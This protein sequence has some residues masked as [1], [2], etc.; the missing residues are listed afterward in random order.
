MR[1]RLVAILAVSLV[2]CAGV[3]AVPD[4]GSNSG[5][6]LRLGSGGRVPAPGDAMTGGAEGVA[7]LHYNPA[8]L[9]W[10]DHQ[11]VSALYQ[12]LVLGINRGEM[13]F[14]RPYGERY[15]F[16]FGISYL[17]YGTIERTTISRAG[18][19]VTGTAAGEFGAQDLAANFSV[20]GRSGQL[21]WGVTG[22]F[23]S[24]TID[25]ISSVAGAF[26]AGAQ[27]RLP[28][29]PFSVGAVI[30]NIGTG[31]KFDQDVE[32]LPKVFRV[33][34]SA[35]FFDKKLGLYADAE[36][37][38]NEEVTTMVGAE[39]LLFDL[40]SLRAGYDGR[41]DVDKGLTLGLGVETKKYEFNYAYVP[42][43]DFG[44]TH[45]LGM[46]YH[47]RNVGRKEAQTREKSW[48][49]YLG[50][51]DEIRKQAVEQKLDPAPLRRPEPKSKPEPVIVPVLPPAPL[52][53]EPV[54]DLSTPKET[55]PVETQVQIEAVPEIETMSEMT[56][57]IKFKVRRLSFRQIHSD[58]ETL[59]FHRGVGILMTDYL[60]S[61]FE[62]QGALALEFEEESH[63]VSGTYQITGNEIAL[64]LYIRQGNRV[65][66]FVKE[67]LD[68]GDIL[69]DSGFYR[70]M[71][72][73][74]YKQIE[75]TEHF[76]N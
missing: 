50:K 59:D 36:K 64:S 38:N 75:E 45:R 2:V 51:K 8:G 18:A 20:G 73:K 63:E 23:I 55:V 1:L 53:V 7:S 39:V 43:G 46:V 9:A 22:K 14:V 16:G 74:I 41:I 40:V 21:A 24:S 57:P 3:S 37:V 61:M 30:K 48:E 70:R 29:H 44:T 32:N 56:P 11:E 76:S 67:R 42:F 27:W 26:D 54:L 12:K 13:S 72:E 28:N 33:G 60:K 10:T 62:S 15:G 19:F 66:G 25:E 58:S 31:L 71:A 17:D 65:V 69:K 47:F 49:E 35:K 52:V 5:E 4:G 68:I 34:A 6:F